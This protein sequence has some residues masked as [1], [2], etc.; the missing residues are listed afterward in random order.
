[1]NNRIFYDPVDTR[2]DLEQAIRELPSNLQTVFILKCFDGLKNREIAEVLHI[3]IKTVESR[4]TKAF[5]LLR[6]RLE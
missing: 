2:L 1:M 6:E 4:V 3:S 5:C